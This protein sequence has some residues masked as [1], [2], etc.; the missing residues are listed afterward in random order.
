M[1]LGTYARDEPH[2]QLAVIWKGSPKQDWQGVNGALEQRWPSTAP[3]RLAACCASVSRSSMPA[4]NRCTKGFCMDELFGMAW[5]HI[6]EAYGHASYGGHG[7]F[8][9]PFVDHENDA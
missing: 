7:G 5:G 1:C 6:K 3:Y 4:T 8:G 9:W 2:H